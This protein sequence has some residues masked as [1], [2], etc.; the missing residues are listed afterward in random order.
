MSAGQS[1]AV[2]GPVVPVGED[3]VVEFPLGTTMG[4]LE[5]DDGVV[6]A[7]PEAD[8]RPVEGLATPLVGPDEAAVETTDDDDDDL[9]VP[10]GA[11]LFEGTPD[12]LT[13]PVPIEE[14]AGGRDVALPLAVGPLDV[15]DSPRLPPPILG[16][17][18][19]PLAEDFA[20]VVMEKPLEGLD[21][22][23]L[24]VPLPE[25]AGAVVEAGGAGG[26]L[27]VEGRLVVPL[28]EGGAAVVEAGG[29]EGTLEDD[30]AP[31]VLF[32]G[33]AEVTLVAGEAE[34]AGEDADV[35]GGGAL[36]VPL[37]EAGGR[38]ELAGEEGVAVGETGLRLS[39]D[40]DGEGMLPVLEVVWLGLGPKDVGFTV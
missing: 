27:D 34:D 3:G 31:G 22:G 26:M 13:G 18:V 24:V 10:I 2:G 20:D 39:V 35:D 23:T 25:G 29:A 5:G 4:E 32:P 19:G 15:S 16:L 28:P 38:T 33:D 17:P 37:P 30:G 1:D 40:P 12:E 8:G 7:L 36:E 6:V 11:V 21:R 14:D 9:P